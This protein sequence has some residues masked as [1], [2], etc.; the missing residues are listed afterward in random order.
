MKRK[1]WFYS[2]TIIV[3]SLL[4]LIGCKK[5]DDSNDITVTDIDGNVYNT[6][7]IGTQVW[8]VEN[9]KTTKYRDGTDI[10][11]VTDDT[12]WINLTTGAYCD[13]NNSPSYSEIYGRLYNWYAVND[14]KNIAPQG[15]HVA[16]DEEWA[17]LATFLG[18]IGVTGSKIKESGTVHWNSPNKGASNASG[19]TALPAGGRISGTFGYLGMATA[20][21]TATEFNADNGWTREVDFDAE[22]LL[23]GTLD[24]SIGFSVRCIKD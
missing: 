18:G 3:I 1:I 19:F 21:W 12:V 13:Y 5:D 2:L 11:N 24:K 20:W 8:L 9:L 14:S 4:C 17:T 16:T 22:D 7:T 6:V 10:P 23:H 15:W